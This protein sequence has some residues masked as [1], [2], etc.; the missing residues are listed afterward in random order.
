MDDE[1][2]PFPWWKGSDFS[3]RWNEEQDRER[4][5]EAIIEALKIFENMINF[6][7]DNWDKQFGSQL[8]LTMQEHENLLRDA[9]EFAQPKP[10]DKPKQP[11]KIIP[12]HFPSDNFLDAYIF[13]DEVPPEERRGFK[14][15]VIKK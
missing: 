4:R 2:P 12:A 3:R 13:D 10:K 8:S 14:L 9:L 1:K 7:D 11:R 5:D 15:F 6:I